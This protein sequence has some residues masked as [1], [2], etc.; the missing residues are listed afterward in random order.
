M[1]YVTATELKQNL[2]HYLELSSTEP[3]YIT[4]NKNVIAVLKNPR[5]EAFK[6]FFKLSGSLKEY[7]DG[8]DY[9]DIVGDEVMKKC[10]F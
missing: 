10:G 8:R 5:D 1:C 4:K 6:D 9:K 3:V 2:S 7:D